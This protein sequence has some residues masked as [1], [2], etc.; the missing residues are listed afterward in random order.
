[1]SLTEQDHFPQARTMTVADDEFASVS[2]GRIRIRIGA[3]IFMLVLLL[4]VLR[5]AEISLFGDKRGG[6]FLPK[7]ITT[8]RADITDRNG[9]VL[10]TTLLNSAT[11]KQSYEKYEEEA[12]RIGKAL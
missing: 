9:E 4:V 10:A 2:E 1:M 3:F 12:K 11:L 5:L 7:E 6:N 8:T